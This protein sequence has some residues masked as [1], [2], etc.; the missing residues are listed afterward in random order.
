MI[1]AAAFLFSFSRHTVLVT[2]DQ[3]ENVLSASPLQFPQIN[4]DFYKRYKQLLRKKENQYD[5][6]VPDFLGDP[7]N[8]EFALWK[9]PK[10]RTFWYTEN[11]AHVFCGEAPG[12]KFSSEN[13][14]I[15][16]II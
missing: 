5:F 2:L 6:F 9:N 15:T 8:Y 12:V 10:Y 14:F 4:P 7:R 1:L 13:C 3:I 16:K 11:H